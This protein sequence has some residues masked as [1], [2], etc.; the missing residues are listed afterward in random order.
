MSPPLTSLFIENLQNPRWEDYEYTYGYANNRFGY[1][2]NGFTTR[3]LDGRDTTWYYGLL[4][5]HKDEQP[6][7]SD[8]RPIYSQMFI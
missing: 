4:E 7:Y 5:E 8:L 1:W 3:E 2:G 6:D